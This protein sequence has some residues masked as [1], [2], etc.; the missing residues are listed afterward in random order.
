MTG[1]ATPEGAIREL[2][3][4]WTDAVRR[5]DLPA[6]LAHHAQDIVM[7]DLP[8]P[9]QAKG[10]E[11]YRKTWDLFFQYHKP[12]QD[13]DIEELAITAGEDVAFAFGIVR[14]GSGPNPAG[15]PFRLTVGLRKIG[16]EWRVTHEHHSIPAEDGC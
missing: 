5:H 6:I 13:F 8:P 4:A 11:E 1:Q 15:F 9:L 16:G 2:L 12:S 7:F 10:M 3:E 14:C